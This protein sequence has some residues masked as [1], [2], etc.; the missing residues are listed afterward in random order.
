MDD[1]TYFANYKKACDVIFKSQKNEY[2][3]LKDTNFKYQSMT[4][5]MGLLIGAASPEDFVNLSIDEAL[6]KFNL[7][8][9]AS[10]RTDQF[11]SQDLNVIK[12][13]KK[14]V[15]L[16]VI[17]NKS[18]TSEEVSRIVVIYKSPIINHHTQSIVGIHGQ[19][20]DLLWPNVIK[21]IFKLRGTKGLLLNHHNKRNSL[22]DY[23]LNNIQH[24]VLFLC[25]HKYSYSEISIFLNELGNQITSSRVNDYLEQLKLIF[26]VRTKDQLI[27]KAIGLN[28]H[29]MLP[30]DL[31]S[32]SE[33]IKVNS[34]VATV[35]CCNC[36]NGNCS[37]HNNSEKDKSK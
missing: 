6:T 11:Q 34:E 20:R 5:A 23:P 35:I 14:G 8:C 21:T 19:I 18:A 29:V 1:K 7:T 24:M 27:E 36:K 25:I 13:G 12:S 31:F 4:E 16:E 10:K 9:S 37:E 30:C 22:N 26:H 15:Y 32:P 33:T 3:Y 28:F 2:S 17:P